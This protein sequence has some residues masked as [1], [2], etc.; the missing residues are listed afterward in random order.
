MRLVQ[1]QKRSTPAFE[2]NGFK[3]TSGFGSGLDTSYTETGRWG[4]T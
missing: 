2:G 1:S 3:I 4:G